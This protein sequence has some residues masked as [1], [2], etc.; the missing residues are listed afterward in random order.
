MTGPLLIG[1]LALLSNPLNSMCTCAISSIR[2]P[3]ADPG[4]I[5]A[6]RPVTWSERD[7][8]FVGRA[9]EVDRTETGLSKRV[10]F[11]V[12][13]SWRGTAA[14]TVTLEIGDNAPCAD[15]FPGALYLV[16][17]DAPRSTQPFMTTAPCDISYSVAHERTLEMLLE[18]GPPP[19]RAP[20]IGTRSIDERV[21]QLGQAPEPDSVAVTVGIGLDPEFKISLVRVADRSFAPGRVLQLS[22]PVGLY[23]LRIEWSD[24]RVTDAYL[25]V[26]CDERPEGIGCY[27]FRFMPDLRTNLEEAWTR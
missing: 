10:R 5:A 23:V 8:I 6:E 13:A 21:V 11:A 9:L 1:T 17:A 24:G 25:S 16:I 27:A 20:A 4:R 3:L 15:Y 19:R 2:S 26:R 22:L 18:L 12:E 14:D 7:Y